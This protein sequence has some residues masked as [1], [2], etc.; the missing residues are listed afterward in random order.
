M[1]ER[2][3][4]SEAGKV[5]NGMVTLLLG[6]GLARIIGL[7]CIPVLARI[8]SPEDFGVL[9]LYAAF[10]A[11]LVP[12]MTLRYVQAIPL[13]KNDVIAFNLF[14]VCFKLIVF[15]SIML[16]VVL[17]I[18]AKPILNFF[19]MEAL[20]PWW[21]MLVLGATGAA[22]Y[23]L[24]SLWATRKKDYKVI[25]K[26]Q[27][28]QSLIGNLA[29]IGLGLLAIKPLGLIV[30]QFLTQSAGITAFIKSARQDFN[31]YSPRVQ[32]GKEKF[33]AKYYQDFVWYRLPSQF[34]MVFSVQAPVV[35]MAAL[36]SNE[37]TGQLSL[38]IMALS[39]PVGLIGNAMAKAYYAEIAALGKNRIGQIRKIT[40]AV[41]KNLFG[42]GVPAVFIAYFTAE[43]LF[44]L[45][46]GEE[47][48]VAG[49]YAVM[50][51]PFILLQFTSSPIVQA[52]NIVGS[53]LTF[54]LINIMRFVGLLGVYFVS[55]RYGFSEEEF[56]S[57][58]SAFLCIF[59][60][61]MT[62]FLLYLMR[63]AKLDD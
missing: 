28:T 3:F 27:F 35:F 37:S 51:S 23:E 60:S 5:L 41:Q 31:S 26:T 48:T 9:A 47:W 39:L 50:L 6:A 14:S 59:Y 30:G 15:F 32:L 16:T 10:V 36:Y 18:W 19:D 58:I 63:S 24:F 12:V 62:F 49:K 2:I 46:F 13:P 57:T 34:L 54:L 1:L 40:I 8:Y 4:K 25:A 56:V 38:A 53:Q 21:W 52:I 44:V 55:S 33:V 45:L 42:I 20:L 43:P 29:K 17:A 22:L 61:V 11:V 7:L